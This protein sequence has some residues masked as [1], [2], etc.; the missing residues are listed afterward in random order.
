MRSGINLI[1]INYLLSFSLWGLRMFFALFGDE[2]KL[3]M[4]SIVSL[5]FEE[6]LPAHMHIPKNYS[7]INFKGLTILQSQHVYT[8]AYHPKLLMRILSIRVRDLKTATHFSPA[9]CVV[10]SFPGSYKLLISRSSLFI[11]FIIF[12]ILMASSNLPLASNQAG[13]S[14]KNLKW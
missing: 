10:S 9:F 3:G 11:L 5:I 1:M 6:L 4:K 2:T 12:T 8:K 13:D 7:R 14:S